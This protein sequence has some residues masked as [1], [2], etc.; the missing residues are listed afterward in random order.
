MEVNV[1]GE[2]FSFSPPEGTPTECW[3]VFNI[4]VDD[5]LE[6]TVTSVNGWVEEGICTTSGTIGAS[7]E[8]PT[9]NKSPMQKAIEAKYYDR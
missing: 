9:I 7:G 1:Q 5:A 6:G 3:H 4:V 8:P 2:E